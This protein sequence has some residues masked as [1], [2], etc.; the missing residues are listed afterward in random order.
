[1]TKRD[2]PARPDSSIVM[3]DRCGEVEGSLRI[4]LRSSF[5]LLDKKKA[6]SWEID[7]R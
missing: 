4:A 3:N 7:S 1:M 5:S 2:G 6:G